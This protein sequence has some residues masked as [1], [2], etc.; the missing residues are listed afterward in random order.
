VRARATT[1]EA[2]AWLEARTGLF[3]SRAAEGVAAVDTR[4]LIRGVVAF[5][6][7]TKNACQAHMAADAPIAWRVLLRAAFEYVF[8][9][10][11]K[12]VI[13]AAIPA[14]NIPSLRFA[15]HVGLV[16][17]YR[18]RDGWDAGDDLVELELRKEHCRWL[19][20]QRKAA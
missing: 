9:Q 13:F 6:G 17:V 16:E 2:L 11:G 3:L 5:E 14:H 1:P 18:L 10:A 19:S 20:S 15:K 12:G 4:G 7:W 8:E